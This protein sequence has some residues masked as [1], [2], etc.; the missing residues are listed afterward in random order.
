MKNY[1]TGDF[2]LIQRK[3]KRVITFGVF[4][5]FHI[6]HLRL[7]KNIRKMVGEPC[8][9]IVA[10]QDGDYINKTKPGTQVLY[11]T[12]ERK[13]FLTS[14]KEIDEVVVY[15]FSDT[16]IHII[17]FDVLAVGPDQTN[18]HFQ[19]CFEYCSQNEKQIIITPRTEGISSTDIKERL[20]I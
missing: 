19:K 16:M 12:E 20:D 17:D 10:M 5:F 11:S 8:Y 14:I 9:L 2:N 13:E 7:F 6:G 15:T 3:Q 18:P 1:K 4:D